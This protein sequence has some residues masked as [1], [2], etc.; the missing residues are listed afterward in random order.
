MRAS[1]P[2][3]T[4]LHADMDAFYASIEQRDCPKLRGRP[5]V[6]GGTG[7][8]GVVATC[9]YEAR[10]YGVRSAMPAV[11]ARR[12]CPTGIFLTPRMG[13]YAG[14]SRKVHKVF[15]RYTPLVE[16][17]SLDEAFLDV[18]GSAALFGSGREIALRIK[19]EI[20]RETGLA[21][22][23][24]IAPC[25]YAAKV[26][27]DLDKPD[28][29]VETGADVTGFLAPLPVSYLW[30]AGPVVQRKLKEMGLRRIEDVQRHSL[31]GLCRILGDG[32]GSHFYRLVRGLDPRPVIPQRAPGSISQE[33]TF[34]QDLEE[35]EA[36]RRVLFELSEQVGRRL[37]QQGLLGRTIRIKV[38]YGDFTT[39][40]RQQ[41]VPATNSD[42]LIRRHAALLLDQ[43]WPGRPG[44]RLLGV[45]VAGLVRPTSP[46]QLSLFGAESI[47]GGLQRAIDELKTRFGGRAVT[48][49]AALRNSSPRARQ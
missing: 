34:H 49:A 38:R 43:A 19:S 33:E 26:A 40:T 37:R 7:R 44:I 21:A 1:N 29:L 25:K 35:R 8:R 47:A 23:V 32:L 12:R 30:G 10:V 6:V 18:T 45:A 15:E 41:V 24:G 17:L 27:S 48:V 16:P 31:E 3:R 4:I 20:Y 5:V 11:E 14:E 36:C 22:S 13:V 28:G 2:R 9:S 39:F 42:L 46:T